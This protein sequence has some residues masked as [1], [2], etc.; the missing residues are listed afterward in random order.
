MRLI[1]TTITI[2]LFVSL[3]S[4]AQTPVNVIEQIKPPTTAVVLV[5]TY[6]DISW[7]IAETTDK[8]TKQY[9]FGERVKFKTEKGIP[10]FHD[11]LAIPVTVG[12]D[13]TIKRLLRYLNKSSVKVDVNWPSIKIEKEGIY[14]FGFIK[15]IVT[16]AN[17]VEV[18]FTA[19]SPT[20]ETIDYAKTLYPKVF[21]KLQPINF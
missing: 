8:N 4:C 20:K 5:G 13:F 12:S 1:N 9:Y 11:V 14:Y 15:S 19:G 6:G 21:A 18:S 17:T 16:P 7:G 3:V 10:R 2:F